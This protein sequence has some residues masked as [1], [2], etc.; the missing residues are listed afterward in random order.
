MSLSINL[1]GSGKYCIT[2]AIIITSNFSGL[3]E[4]SNISAYINSR[5]CR[6]LN[7]WVACLSSVLFISTPVT[8]DPFI[9]DR[10]WLNQPFPQPISSI[11]R[12]DFFEER[13]FTNFLLLCSRTFHSDLNG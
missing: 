9:F 3:K 13:Y 5:F 7:T 6:W 8:F 12:E 1:P 10:V 2:D 11:F 4:D